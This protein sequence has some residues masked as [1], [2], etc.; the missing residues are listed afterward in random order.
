[1]GSSSASGGRALAS[2]MTFG[3]RLQ[4]PCIGFMWFP[5][6]AYLIPESGRL[7]ML[8]NVSFFV[9]SLV[10]FVV[11]G[12]Y[13]AYLIKACFHTMML[14]DFAVT[15]K[16]HSMCYGSA[17]ASSLVV[18]Q[19]PHL[20]ALAAPMATRASP[21]VW[22]MNK[23]LN[24]TVHASWT[25]EELR[26][27][28]QEHRQQN[29]ES[30][31]P[32]G[33]ASMTLAELKAKATELH[34]AY[35]DRVT[36]GHLQKL[37]RDMTAPPGHEVVSFGRMREC[38]ANPNS[39]DELRRMANY[40]RQKFDPTNP[41]YHQTPDSEVNAKIPYEPSIAESTAESSVRSHQAPI[42]PK[43][44][45]KSSGYSKTTTHKAETMEGRAAAGM[46]QDVPQEVTAEIQALQTRL[47]VL[48]P[49]GQGEDEGQVEREQFYD[50][51]ED[52][53]N[54][55]EKNIFEAANLNTAHD[56][57]YEHYDGDGKVSV[58]AV[59]KFAQDLRKG[60]EFTFERCSELLHL[61]CPLG[62]NLA[63]RQAHDADDARLTL[64]AFAHGGKKSYDLPETLRYL[65]A[66]CKQHGAKG[67][68]SA[69]S[70]ALNGGS[71]LHRDQHNAWG[72]KNQ[73]ISFGTYVG[74]RL[75]IEKTDETP[76]YDTSPA[77][78][79]QHD[80]LLDNGKEL[81][82]AWY[83]TF[84]KF[85]TFD[86]RQ[87]HRPEPWQ[88]DRFT[89][90]L[91]TPRGVEQLSR[92]ERDQLRSFGFP[93][94]NSHKDLP[95]GQA[96]PRP[97]S[98]KEAH[99]RPRKSIRKQALKASAMLTLSMGAASSFLTEHFGS[100]S[101]AQPAIFEV[102]G[103][104]MTHKAVAWGRDVVEPL[105]CFNQE[106]EALLVSNLTMELEP[107]VLWIHGEDAGPNMPEKVKHLFQV[108]LQH[109]GVAVY[110]GLENGP[111]WKN[112]EFEDVFPGCD[113]SMEYEDARP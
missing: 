33:L 95:C 92:E 53:L 4:R 107:R 38:E 89:I 83:P 87:R 26:S 30:K 51:F 93:V 108:Q 62:R 82:G 7:L 70:I 72:E 77:I 14:G 37:I 64:G 88:G 79:E 15:T 20:K 9:V 94:S 102:G 80:I 44:M 35:P 110:E 43:S 74:G 46:E 5:D 45:A 10:K 21:N 66:F 13:P 16:I 28:I 1:M 73:C 111:L 99:V 103:F 27:V 52:V 61:A 18:L 32:K 41:L 105:D 47:A 3:L 31:V 24:L 22:H 106:D 101:G 57:H 71:G 56:T 49:A 63:K 42:L 25:R 78:G 86:A 12:E 40:T 113:I 23:Q 104:E 75:W 29:G 54:S 96:G 39:S 67:R 6:A 98:S 34:V 100:D 17:G 90:T 11:P 85:L 84:E 60:K 55:P 76:T 69:M 8:S 97:S 36:K 91:Y 19:R 112:S 65:N 109:G 48:L 2:P 58:L 50:C 81:P 68:W 59:E